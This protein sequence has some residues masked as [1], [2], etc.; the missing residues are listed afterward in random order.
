[1]LG[2]PPKP[3]GLRW[4]SST[5]FIIATVGVGLFCDLFLYGLIV[6]D[7]KL[8]IRPT[9]CLCRSI[10]PFLSSSRHHCGQSQIP[11]SA[12][13]LR[14]AS[15][16]GRDNIIGGRRECMGASSGKNTARD[17]RGGGM[18]G[19]FGA[20]ARHCW[21][22]RPG[23][24]NWFTP[25]L[26]GVLYDK[27]GYAGVFGI[28]A[29][30]LAIDFLMR[31]LLIEKKVAARYEEKEPVD[32][33]TNRNTQ[34]ADDPRAAENGNADQDAV[35]A[36]GAT[37]ESPLLPKHNGSSPSDSKN[38]FKI[39][40]PQPGFITTLP[41]LYTLSDPRLLTALFLGFVQATL[42]ATFDATIPTE[43]SHLFGFT[44]LNAGLLFIALD[45]TYLILGP[46]AG[47]AVD[48][49]G[50]KPA[51]VLGFAYLT[52]MLVLLRLPQPGG[53]T[54]QLV[55]YCG[56]LA[57]NGMGLAVI[58]SPSLV[59]ASNVVKAYD[60]AN[61]GFFGEQGPYAQLYGLNSLFFCAGLTV[62]PVLSGG[63]RDRIGYGD[64]NAVMGALA[65][66]TA[67]LSL[68]YVGGRPAVWKHII[69]RK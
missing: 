61:P 34:N 36:D 20:R 13:P 41:I 68:V 69:S 38:P 32:A 47:W 28:G 23:K 54:P 43:A 12:I 29:L 53:G 37:E 55:L 7:P 8:L 39:P 56:L 19:G 5:F 10:R 16:A 21:A 65:F 33:N 48:K 6:P 2:F 9:C 3:I 27:T 30:V 59:E 51:A 24:D 18:D 60:E 63:L 17:K 50:P 46:L 67:T 49:Y 42:I 11:A 66:V 1:M 15:V 52:P 58:G 44:S 22:G 26:G 64:M 14:T 35:A 4:R 31:I 25:V 62:G 57:L 45:I 40:Q